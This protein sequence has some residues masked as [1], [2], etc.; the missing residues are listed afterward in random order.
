MAYATAPQ[1]R[2]AHCLTFEQAREIVAGPRPVT[3]DDP[4]WFF[5]GGQFLGDGTPRDDYGKVFASP[6]ANPALTRYDF[7]R[8][9]TFARLCPAPEGEWLEV[10]GRLFKIVAV[11]Q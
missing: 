11:S 8:S 6:S 7:D 5:C 4:A 10:Q 2:P 3:H 1:S 9:G